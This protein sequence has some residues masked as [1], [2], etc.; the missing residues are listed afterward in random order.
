[1]WCTLELQ[2]PDDYSPN[3][4]HRALM[5]VL[6]E[7]ESAASETLDCL[8][9]NQGSWVKYGEFDCEDC[10]DRATRLK[11]ALNAQCTD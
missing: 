10:R 4:V 11:W 7:S 5:E 8:R 1:M 3:E 6:S 9:Q 2:L